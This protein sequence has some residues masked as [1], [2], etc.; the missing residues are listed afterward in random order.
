MSEEFG[1]PAEEG[2]KRNTTLIVITVVV[3][4]LLLCCCGSLVAAWYLGDPL[5][6]FLEGLAFQSLQVLV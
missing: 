1:T 5:I 6:E 4:V 2:G 3:L